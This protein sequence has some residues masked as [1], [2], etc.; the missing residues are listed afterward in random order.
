MGPVRVSSEMRSLARAVA[1]A[2]VAAVVWPA[3]ASGAFPGADGR[4]AYTDTTTEGG[5]AIFAIS[6]RGGDRE[7]LTFPGALVDTDAAWSA[8]GT[9]LAFTRRFSDTESRVLVTSAFGSP[10]RTLTPEGSGLVESEPAFSPDGSRIV[11]RGR[12]AGTSFLSGDDEL[13]SIGI[14]GTGLARLTDT[15]GV[16]V[17]EPT[18]APDGRRIAYSRALAGAGALGPSDVYLLDLLSGGSSLVTKRRPNAD[19]DDPSWRPDGKRL[20]YER[21]RRKGPDDV[22]TIRPNGKNSRLM[23]RAP[24]GS[25][26]RDPGYSPSGEK[27]ALHTSRGSQLGISIYDV[28]RKKL[29]FLARASENESDWQP[30]SD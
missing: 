24:D 4:I 10:P 23:L 2:C 3:W 8:D 15:P 12:T 16:V 28:S 25:E 19:D 26:Y 7:Q 17:Q 27:V 14:D 6:P 21:E 11:F 1:A 5:G 30:L 9:Q 22:A 18:F 29:R 13:Y 20:V